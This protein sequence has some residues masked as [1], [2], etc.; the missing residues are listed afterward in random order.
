MKLAA[1][2]SDEGRRIVQAL[3][4]AKSPEQVSAVVERVKQAAIASML[5]ER[6]A[7]AGDSFGR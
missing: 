2:M 6:R 4:E 7:A 3:Y 1:L 5:G